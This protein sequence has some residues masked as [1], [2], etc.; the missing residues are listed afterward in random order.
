MHA[1]DDPNSLFGVKGEFGK[2]CKRGDP[3]QCGSVI[4]LQHA[5]TKKFLHSHL[6]VSP[7]SRQQEVSGYFPS[8]TGDN[9]VV[10]CAAGKAVLERETPFRLK[11]K[12][13]NT[14]LSTSKDHPFG[15]PIQGQL[16]VACVKTASPET[17]WLAVEGV[18][19]S[20]D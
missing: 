2:S 7:L 14:Y 20:E 19:I 1:R 3:I 13:T 17:L 4:R 9:W 16:E 12:D 18:Y 6:H 10:V 15:H 8:D 5:N 11:H